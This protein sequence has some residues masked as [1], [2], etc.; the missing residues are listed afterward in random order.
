MAVAGRRNLVSYPAGA[1]VANMRI[2]TIASDGQIDPA[3]GSTLRP[4]GITDTA[5][6]A[7]GQ[8]V[9]VAIEGSDVKLE[10]GAAIDEGQYVQAVAGG[11]GSALPTGGTGWIVGVCTQPASGSGAIAG[12][13]VSP[14]HIVGAANP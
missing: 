13:L 9:A 11:R 12:V 6:T 4:L 2:V 1:A 3:T 7:A 8:G 14:E 10:A 5:A